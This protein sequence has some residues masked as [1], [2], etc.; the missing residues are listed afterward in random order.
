MSNYELV[1]ELKN[2]T[3]VTRVH[4]S[5]ARQFIFQA[6]MTTFYCCD[7]LQTVNH[8][9]WM[10]SYQG[11]KKNDISGTEEDILPATYVANTDYYFWG[12]ERKMELQNHSQ[13]NVYVKAHYISVKNPLP[14]GASGPF[15]DAR[16]TLDPADANGRSHIVQ[17]LVQGWINRYYDA[18]HSTSTPESTMAWWANDQYF[19]GGG[20]SDGVEFDLGEG[21]GAAGQ[22]V[23]LEWSEGTALPK[24][25]V[26][27]RRG[28]SIYES[29]YFTENFRVYHTKSFVLGPEC[30]AHLSL[31]DKELKVIEFEKESPIDGLEWFSKD[32]YVNNRWTKYILFEV[33]GSPEAQSIYTTADGTTQ[34]ATDAATDNIDLSD[35][36]KNVTTHGGVMRL[37]STF[38]GNIGSFDVPEPPVSGYSTA[39]QF[40]NPEFVPAKQFTDIALADN[41][42]HS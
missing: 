16:N 40:A 37:I 7:P 30:V 10:N 21:G 24:W 19:H 42:E 23:P 8:Q 12:Q 28:M 17:C 11:L 2:L 33:V 38:T 26:S 34:T 36:L 41:H 39:I 32:E 5:N 9:K 18:T 27:A 35:A 25:G 31:A 13:A 20:A 6:G 22:G 1:K 4:E 29:D 15:T 3:G 14:V